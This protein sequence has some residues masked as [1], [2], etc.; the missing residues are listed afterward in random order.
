MA[1]RAG[2]AGA[3]APANA[4]IREVEGRILAS[5]GQWNGYDAAPP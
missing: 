3:T 5:I 1:V 2:F 4:A